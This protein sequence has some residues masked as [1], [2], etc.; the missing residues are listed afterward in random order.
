MTIKDALLTLD[1]ENDEQW[2]EE[3]LPKIDIIASLVNPDATDPTITVDMITEAIP[4]FC[5]DKAKVKNVQ[6]GPTIGQLDAR[7]NELSGQRNDLDGQIKSLQFQRDR[8]QDQETAKDSRASDMQGVVDYI[9]SQG[10]LRAARVNRSSQLLKGLDPKTINPAAPID[11]AMARKKARGETRPV[12]QPMNLV[13]VPN[14][15]E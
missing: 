6:K 5:R 3:G 2:T 10:A 9:K 11:Q 7:I 8:L 1:P 14:Q 13:P 15:G 12:R 4:G